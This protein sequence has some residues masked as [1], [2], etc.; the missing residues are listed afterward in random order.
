MS[1]VTQTPVVIPVLDRPNAS[2]R[3]TR[4]VVERPMSP[5]SAAKLVVSVGGPASRLI[6]VMTADETKSLIAAL[7]AQLDA[8][9]AGR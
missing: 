9:E 3:Q 8:K 7:Q 2:D 6:V 5:H 1:D 4:V